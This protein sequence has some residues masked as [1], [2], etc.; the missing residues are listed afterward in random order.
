MCLLYAL[1]AYEHRLK[2]LVSVHDKVKTIQSEFIFKN[3]LFIKI[4]HH[5]EFSM[6]VWC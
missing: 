6:V 4:G 1:K 2:F 5:M 3:H